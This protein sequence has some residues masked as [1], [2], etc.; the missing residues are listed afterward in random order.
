MTVGVVTIEELDGF[1][2]TQGSGHIDGLPWYYR[3][4]GDHWTLSVASR[5]HVNPIDVGRDG[6]DG[7]CWEGTDDFGGFVPVEIAERL[8]RDL[9]GTPREGWPA[10]SRRR[11]PIRIGVPWDWERVFGDE[12]EAMRALTNGSDERDDGAGEA[13]PD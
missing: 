13:T 7:W 6:V 11:V 10:V 5:P 8:I 2:P 9:L 12:A 3:S 4:R 1:C